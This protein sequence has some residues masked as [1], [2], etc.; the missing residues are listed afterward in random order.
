MLMTNS[1]GEKIISILSNKKLSGV[2]AKK[3]LGYAAIAGFAALLYASVYIKSEKDYATALE[4]YQQNSQKEAEIASKNIEGSLAQIYQGIRTISLLPSVKTIDRYGK[5]LDANAHES[6]TQIYRNMASNV[7][8][9]EV[10]IVPVDLEPD[11]IDP[12]TKGLQEPILMFDG[13]EPKTDAAEEEK[14]P[15]TSVEQAKQVSEVEIY[16]YQLLKDQMS[17]LKEKYPDQGHIDKLNLPFIGGHEVL[18]CDNNDFKTTKKDEDRTGIVLSVPFFGPN[19]L[20]KG[21]I[22]AVIRN[23]VIRDMLP[24]AHYALVNPT[25]HYLVMP[26]DSAQTTASIQW[27][28]DNKPDPSLLFST[29][30]PVATSDPLGKWSLWAGY[31]NEMFENSGDRQAVRNFTIAGYVLVTFLSFVCVGIYTL[32]YKN[33]ER[34]RHMNDEFTR[35]EY[36]IKSGIETVSGSAQQLAQTSETMSDVSYNTSEKANSAASESDQATTYLQSI[37]TSVDEMANSA[38]NISNQ[39]LHSGDIVKTTVEKIHKAEEISSHLTEANQKISKVVEIIHSIASQIDLLAIN[40]AVEAAHAGESGKGF[41]VVA[42]E[43]KSLAK[44]TSQ[45]TEEISHQIEHIQSVSTKVVEIFKEI[46]KSI[47]EVE[48]YSAF[49]ETAA[50]DQTKSVTRIVGNISAAAVGIHNI[51]NYIKD[52][53]DSA[54]R[55]SDSSQEVLSAA[56]LLTDESDSLN[57]EVQ[58]FLQKMLQTH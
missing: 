15:V 49:V 48:Q 40:A 25:Y 45:A 56:K 41:S 53:M 28:K 24:H 6:I 5:N 35:F 4:H 42:G 44:Q 16:E 33:F 22:T 14:A 1:D 57:K 21:T 23:N 26:K 51:A 47:M 3:L 38:K 29:I 52:V 46:K 19:G 43:V 17:Y 7:A 31:P 8:V 13:S 50:D 20:L 32:I 12:A 27:I 39:I 11:Q 37:V 2:S 10:Y 18:T 58:R 55:A 30:I 36:K 54:N 34:I 9:S